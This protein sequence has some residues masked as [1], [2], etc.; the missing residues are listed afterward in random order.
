MVP[1]PTS[2]P[3]VW[4]LFLV[5]CVKTDMKCHFQPGYDPLSGWKTDE[6]LDAHKFDVVA[7]SLIAGYYQ[8]RRLLGLSEAINRSAHSMS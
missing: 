1:I 4:A 3:W 5:C 7:I 6:F 2:F 8:Y